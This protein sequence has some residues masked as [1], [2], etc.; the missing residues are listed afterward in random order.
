[1]V[2]RN[3]LALGQIAVGPADLAGGA[4]DLAGGAA[5]LALWNS[6]FPLL[7]PF[8][9]D[10]ENNC[11]TNRTFIFFYCVHY[12][13]NWLITVQQ[14]IGAGR[15]SPLPSLVPT[16]ETIIN[17]PHTHIEFR[18]CSPHNSRYRALTCSLWFQRV[19]GWCNAATMADVVCL[20]VGIR[21]TG[22]LRSRSHLLVKL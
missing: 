9:A 19:K 20:W 11:K 15:C 16:S 17:S 18:P 12:C 13:E 6:L 10:R 5:D 4:A 7:W 22:L 14:N 8:S 3:T 1:M 21:C 2:E